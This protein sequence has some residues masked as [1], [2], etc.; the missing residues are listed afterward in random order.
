MTI[1]NKLK[2]EHRCPDT[3]YDKY[4]VDVNDWRNPKFSAD[5]RLD[6]TPEST[7]DNPCQSCRWHKNN[8]S[9]CRKFALTVRRKR[10]GCSNWKRK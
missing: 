4:G 2:M 7:N 6:L 5:E 3:E 1:P 8:P 10:S 9:Y